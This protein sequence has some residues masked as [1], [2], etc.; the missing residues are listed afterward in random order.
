MLSNSDHFRR[1]AGITAILSVICLVVSGLTWLAAA[2][3]DLPRATEPS[4]FASFVDRL[5]LLRASLAFDVAA[6]VLLVPLIAALWAEYDTIH[7][8]RSR[9]YAAGGLAYSLVG[10]TGA[11]VLFAAWPPL[12]HTLAATSSRAE[13]EAILA[14]FAAFTEVVYRGMWNVVGAAG[15]GTWLLGMGTLMR[16]TRRGL[17]SLGI[18]AGTAALVDAVLVLAGA[19]Q[20]AKMALGLLGVLGPLWILLVAIDLV[21]P[22][23]GGSSVTKP[24][25]SPV[26]QRLEQRPVLDVREERGTT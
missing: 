1:A 22:I 25:R 17:G 11:V 18:A 8:A 2:E 19:E 9:M 6:Y 14:V 24:G 13:Q 3:W 26:T 7:P 15:I 21:R 12:M 4:G 23:D 10:A 5:D 16:P 20:A